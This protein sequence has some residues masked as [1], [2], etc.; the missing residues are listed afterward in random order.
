MEF[1]RSLHAEN[2]QANRFLYQITENDTYLNTNITQTLINPGSAWVGGILTSFG[3][4][5]LSVFLTI[6]VLFFHSKTT[7]KTRKNNLIHFL[8]ALSIGTLMGDSLIHL[9]PECYGLEEEPNNR[10]E[11]SQPTVPI[12]RPNKSLVAFFILFG[13]LIIYIF[14]KV[15][16]LFGIG[17]SHGPSTSQVELQSIENDQEDNKNY[18]QKGNFVNSIASIDS[19]L[20]RKGNDQDLVTEIL[21]KSN[22]L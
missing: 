8:I 20:T 5:L 21:D 22:I 12:V 1:I 10:K 16:I 14:E 18:T 6:L 4:Y 13:F 11:T 19:D 17:H 9:L 15:L 7:S 2:F 3:L